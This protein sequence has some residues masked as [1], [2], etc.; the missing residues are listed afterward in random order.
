MIIKRAILIFFLTMLIV[1]NPAF[2]EGKKLKEKLSKGTFTVSSEVKGCDVDTKIFCPGLKPGSEKNMMCLMAF[3]EKISPNCRLGLVE[4]AL[5]VKMGVK[6]I[7]YSVKSCEQDADKLCLDVNPGKG[8]IVQC[9]KKHKDK[10]SQACITA[11][12]ETGIWDMGA[13]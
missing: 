9:L 4:A 6:A 13:K 10:V 12:K 5:S 7:D 8:Q 2:A 11:L 1:S 3:E